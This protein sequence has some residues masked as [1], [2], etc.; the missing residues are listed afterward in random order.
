MMISFFLV[1]DLAKTPL[2]ITSASKGLEV[3]EVTTPLFKEACT[4]L[5]HYE[6]RSL[7]HLILL[8][9]IAGGKDNCS[10]TRMK[11]LS[12]SVKS[13]SLDSL[14]LSSLIPALVEASVFSV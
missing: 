9:E 4:M 11:K 6:S 3:A 7:W 5:V 10:K 8:E 2:K 12:L 13:S 1:N 14:L